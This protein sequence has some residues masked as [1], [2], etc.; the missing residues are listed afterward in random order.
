MARQL[1]KKVAEKVD[2]EEAY[3]SE[4][5]IQDGF[6]FS[7]ILFLSLPILLYLALF[8]HTSDDLNLLTGAAGTVQGYEN[9]AGPWG[10]W[11]ARF[12]FY[13]FGL[14]TWPIVLMLFLWVL[15]PF[16][17]PAVERRGYAGAMLAV[18]FG[19]CILF[20]MNP[21]LFVED[22]FFIR[23]TDSLGIGHVYAPEKALSGGLIGQMLAAPPVEAESIQAGV[24]RRNIGDVGTLVV[25]LV[26]LFL[27]LFFIF[28]QDWK[29][30]LVHFLNVQSQKIQD[31][32]LEEEEKAYSVEVKL[33]PKELESE[34]ENQLGIQ[35]ELELDNELIQQD[36]DDVEVPTLT[37]ATVNRVLERSQVLFGKV[38]T[39]PEFEEEKY[40]PKNSEV[41]FHRES[42]FPQEDPPSPPLR[43]KTIEE[44]IVQVQVPAI[45]TVKEGFTFANN[46]RGIKQANDMKAT[47]QAVTLENASE[48]A[49]YVLPLISML[50]KVEEVPLVETPQIAA[51]REQLLKTL[52]SF[53]IDGEVTDVVVGPRVVRF[54][55]SLAPGVNVKKIDAISQNIAKDL[56]AETVRILA[57]IPG[58]AT[59]GIEVPNINTVGV[60]MR[61]VM[62]SSA[63]TNSKADIPIVLGKDVNG[64]P[65]VT[66]LSSMPHLLIAGAT[67]AG[68]SV[69]MNT[70]IMSLLYRFS[71]DDLKLIMVDPKI[72]EMAM[73]KNLPHL[74]TPV[75]N[76]SGKVPLALRWAVAEM[77][78]RY[79]ILAEERCK[80]IKGFNF[81]DTKKGEQLDAFGKP[82]PAK[83]PYLVIIIDE[84]ADLMMTDARK[85][86]ETSIARIA[87]KG[88][89]AGIHLV[90]AT[91]RPSANIITGVIKANLP[92][93]IAFRVT[94]LIDS[95][96]I[97]DQSGAEKL[98]GKGDMLFTGTMN[99][100]RIQGAF[101]QDPD[102]EKVVDFVCA[103]RPQKFLD[104][105]LIDPEEESV[106]VVD[107]KSQLRMNARDMEGDSDFDEVMD[108]L[109][110]NP[111]L[112]KYIYPGDSNYFRQALEILYRDRNISTSYI[113]RRLKIG[114][115]KA[116]EIVDEFEKRGIIG[117]QK[118]GGLK[119]DI[120]IFDE[121]AQNK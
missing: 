81:R 86:A 74:I 20:A 85:D 19:L 83:M 18:I 102:I 49:P 118:E 106:A 31:R 58:K 38:E 10:A 4:V 82:I 64:K 72:V 36:D 53:A 30:W 25:S 15:R 55:I 100:E 22:T 92:T 93:R 24:L 1:N 103:Q 28:W 65:F 27:G 94:S 99:L 21:S 47:G 51:A 14:A 109:E 34:V 95:R 89:A 80:N 33:I 68:K 35:T 45:S 50:T 78:R 84:M 91:Q 70:L 8:S 43:V 110:S 87:Q 26:L 16:F 59:I 107:A 23:G 73:Y 113:Q 2:V 67:G 75:V 77:E 97:L 88:R 71:P 39:S 69:C 90:L 41:L 7:Y 3:E 40:E 62:E 115:N 57:P 66:D 17:P 9:W 104:G 11:I 108:E 105:V 60:F 98:L 56:C 79:L 52:T 119:R 5:K 32:E 76:D 120:L 46:E 13:T 29:S 96:V 114:Y 117:P 116:A 54:E 12:F 6:R 121:L 111:I 61:Q 42:R 112:E 48:K 44:Q 101:V 63:W 37:S